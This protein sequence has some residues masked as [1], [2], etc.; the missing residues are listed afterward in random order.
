MKI[1]I[2]YDGIYPFIKGGADKRLYE[3]ARGL[4]QRGHEVKWLLGLSKENLVKILII[5][6]DKSI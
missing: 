1:S 5:D 3:I 2:V 6:K 4:V